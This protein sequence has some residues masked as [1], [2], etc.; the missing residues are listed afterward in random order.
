MNELRAIVREGRAALAAGQAA[1]LA[2]VVGVRGS[3][4]RRPG[5]RMLV[6]SEG[7]RAGSISGGCLEADVSRQAAFLVANGR[8]VVRTYDTSDDA[9]AR[10]GCG[11]EVEVL[12]EPLGDGAF[13]EV[14][15]RVA[16]GRQTL[17]LRT[18]L[19]GRAGAREVRLDGG[20]V[21]RSSDAP[22]EGQR[23]FEET[24]TPS[25]KLV[26]V[27]A[28][29]DALPVARLAEELGWS[30]DVYD[31]RPGLLTPARFPT[32]DARVTCPPDDLP[33]RLR[34]EP[35]CVAVVMAHHLDYDAAALAVL[36]R[37][38]GVRCV[39]LLG[40]RHRS[41]QVVALVDAKGPRLTPA[42]RAR[43]RAPVGLDLGAEGPAAIALSILAEAQAVLS[44]REGGALSR[45][46]D[47][48]RAR[49]G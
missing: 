42:H 10:L 27:G 13:L 1:V 47:D 11:G 48:E 41:A 17:S 23:C 21:W 28:G 24:L 39:G 16:E 34:I 12:L 8:A 15:A 49:H 7:W 36:L 35:G 14:L 4:Y 6:T 3:S 38:E 46:T 9:G 2:T 19:E 43:L 33:A 26:L 29:H 45:R 37:D 20:L 31:W 32:A 25:P 30:V 22:L 40:P 44:G 18:A 5:A